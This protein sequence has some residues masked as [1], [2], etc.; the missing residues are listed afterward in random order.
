[1]SLV[2]KPN[3]RISTNIVVDLNIR[4][5]P[6]YVEDKKDNKNDEKLVDDKIDYIL[7]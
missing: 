1:M 4:N 3:K 2:T 6:E 5:H 7:R